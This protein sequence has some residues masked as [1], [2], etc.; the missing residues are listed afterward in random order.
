MN[1]FVELENSLNKDEANYWEMVAD[2]NL[3][4]GSFRDNP[5]KRI[6]LVPKVMEEFELDSRVLEIGVGVGITIATLIV[7]SMGKIKYVGTDLSKRYCD[8]V[9]RHWKVKM[10]NC[11]VRRIPVP[12]KS[13]NTVWAFDSLEHVNPKDREE[14]YKEINR[15]LSDSSKILINVPL[16][17]SQHDTDFDFPFDESDIARLCKATS[18]NIKRLE[19]YTTDQA[20]D[21]QFVVLAK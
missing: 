12:D 8:F 7:V 11:D 15:V 1:P 17:E 6:K 2:A 13:F 14:G 20:R 10:L 9:E 19:K 3:A 5:W 4:D 18:M 16:S 21:Y